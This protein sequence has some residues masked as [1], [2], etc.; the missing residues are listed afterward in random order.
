MPFDALDENQI[1]KISSSRFLALSAPGCTGSTFEIAV[2]R[3]T[4]RR[5]C[6]LLHQ[7]MEVTAECTRGGS[8]TFVMVLRIDLRLISMRTAEKRD[9]NYTSES[10]QHRLC[11][12][13]DSSRNGRETCHSQNH[14][15]NSSIRFFFNGIWRIIG[16]I[17]GQTRPEPETMRLPAHVVIGV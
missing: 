9:R 11:G 15:T 4:L 17:H 3:L 14:H 6:Q 16:T 8:S 1:V 5:V 12:L 13:R 2:F 10:A 7:E